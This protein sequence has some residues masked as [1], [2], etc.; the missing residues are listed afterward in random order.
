MSVS[1]LRDIMHKPLALAICLATVGLAFAQ[2]NL[3]AGGPD[4]ILG[5]WVTPNGEGYVEI[6]KSGDAY[7]GIIVGGADET[8]RLDEKNPDPAL[9]DRPLLGLKIMNGFV[10]DAD[11]RWNSGRIYDPNS[12]KT[13]KSKLELKDADT[14][15]VRGF[16][17]IPLFGRTET[18]TRRNPQ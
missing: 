3:P 5:V 8:P 7:D 1:F 13:Y 12:G 4:A 9:R 18:F 10:Y 17:G 15:D 6:R 14:L 11:T 16:V 2:S